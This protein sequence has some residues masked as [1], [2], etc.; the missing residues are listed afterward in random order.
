M[1]VPGELIGYWNVYNKFGGKLPWKEL[2]QPTIDLCREGIYVTAGL[3]AR[4]K[5]NKDT[6]Y[7]DPILR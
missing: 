1:A 6:L 5:D 7:S 4:Y 3:A 2:V